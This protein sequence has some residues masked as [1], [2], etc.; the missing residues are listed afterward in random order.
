LSM[1]PMKTLTP[2][3]PSQ[4]ASSGKTSLLERIQTEKT[5]RAEARRVEAEQRAYRERLESDFGA[6][7]REAWR[8]NEP[9]KPLV[10]GWPLE[11]V[12][13]HAQALVEDWMRVTLASMG[14]LPP[15]PSGDTPK[16]KAAQEA[17]RIRRH[18]VTG[19]WREARRLGVLADERTGRI[20]VV[21]AGT[22]AVE[23]PARLCEV[24]HPLRQPAG[25]GVDTLAEH[26]GVLPVHQPGRG[27][28]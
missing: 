11:V 19:L 6:F 22:G 28:S 20:G 24:P 23:A 1:P 2:S 18:H 17:E 13:S 10:W 7:F 27:A 5:R 15:L 3:K 14:T 21:N 9:V 4:S 25:V 8:V 26:D 16:D 12:C